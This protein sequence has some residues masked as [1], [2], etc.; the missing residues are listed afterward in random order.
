MISHINL[1][2][3]ISLGYHLIRVRRLVFE[4]LLT[5][6]PILPKRQLVFVQCEELNRLLTI[7]RSHT[8]QFIQE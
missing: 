8:V 3:D 2:V 7:D 6:R 4:S 1:D 5:A